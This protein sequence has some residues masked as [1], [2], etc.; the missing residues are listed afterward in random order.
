M[1]FVSL[2]PRAVSVSP[3]ATYNHM[4]SCI[5]SYTIQKNATPTPNMHPIASHLC[6]S[7]PRYIPHLTY[8]VSIYVTFLISYRIRCFYPTHTIH[9]IA[10]HIY[11]SYLTPNI[12]HIASH[13]CCFYLNCKTN[14]LGGQGLGLT[15]YNPSTSPL[16]YAVSIWAAAPPRFLIS[17]LTYVV[18]IQQLTLLISHL[19]YG[20]SIYAAAPPR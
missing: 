15:P 14:G 11:C 16:T 7:Y 2:Q 17:H 4:Y 13:I 6:C 5:I 18:C 1:L 9:H 19:T 20:V 10:S 8:V 3:P 12:P